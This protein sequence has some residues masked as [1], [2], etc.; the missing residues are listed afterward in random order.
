MV[1]T[2]VRAEV[3]PRSSSSSFSLS[4]L[5]FKLGNISEPGL[6]VVQLRE[7]L[8]GRKEGSYISPTSLIVGFHLCR[9]GLISFGGIGRMLLAT[10]SGMA[11]D[12]RDLLPSFLLGLF[13]ERES[14]WDRLARFESQLCHNVI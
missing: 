1:S 11:S 5:K 8:K 2:M 6:L 4:G 12:M 3:T 9:N 10:A 13:E 14:L 7:H